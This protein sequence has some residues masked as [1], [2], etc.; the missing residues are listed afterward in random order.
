MKGSEKQVAMARLWRKVLRLTRGRVPVLKAL[1]V[2]RAEEKNPAVRDALARVTGDIGEGKGIS[3]AFAVHKALFSP[4]V[5]EL[6]KAAEMSG[7][8]D[9]ILAEIAD[10]LEEGTFD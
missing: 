3:E 2:V 5:V 8:W 7:A 10:G 4:S 1:E 6:L 9:E